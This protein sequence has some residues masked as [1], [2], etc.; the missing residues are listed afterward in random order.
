MK[1]RKSMKRFLATK[2]LTEK[3]VCLILIIP[4]SGCN[5]NWNRSEVPKVSDRELLPT[6]SRVIDEQLEVVLPYLDEELSGEVSRALRSMEMDGRAVVDSTLLEQSGRDY[7]EFGYA[8]ATTEDARMVVDYA[9]TLLPADEFSVLE[10]KLSEARSLMLAKGDEMARAL[11]PHQRPAFMKDM[12]KLVTR[13]IVLLV[14]GIVYA[15]IPNLVFWGKI[16]AAAAIA[17]AAGIVAT[18]IMSIWR[19]YEFDM[20]K[21][22]AFEDWLK[23]VT[24]EPETAYA[25]AASVIAMGATLKRGPIVTGIIL[26]IFAIYNVIDMVK[27]MLKT[28]NFNA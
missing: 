3:L 9:R 12:Q 5:L 27:P 28:Y 24:T 11:P 26:G 8:V 15:C 4:L 18:T 25:L 14:A 7:L 13:T 6:M 1:R 10:G 2:R 20:D 16:T 22:V 23:S 19:Y 21:D 17:I